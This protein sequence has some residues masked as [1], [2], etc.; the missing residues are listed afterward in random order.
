MSGRRS[1]AVVPFGA[2]SSDSR[3]G[4]WGRQ[5]ARRLVDRFADHP[6]LDLKPVFLVAMPEAS[7][8]AGYLVFGSTPDPALAA[9]YGASLGASHA[10]VGVLADRD[11]ERS[12]EA[13][14]VDVATK[15]AVASLR[16]PIPP[17]GLPHAEA[18]LGEWLAASLGA[19]AP[20]APPLPPEPAYAPLLEGMDEEVN[21]TLLAANDPAGSRAARVRA[22][23][24]YLDA[25]RADAGAVAAE[26]RLLVLAAESIERGEERAFVDLL[27]R[28]IEIAP[29]SW[30]GHYLLGELRRL[31]GDAS[32]AV[33]AF[34]HADS[35]QPLRDVDSVRLAELHLATGA[36][37]TA[38]ARLRRI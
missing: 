34:E 32:G 3:A 17:G 29:R 24:R 21:A 7:S 8:D 19:A 28:L 10:L 1:I 33:V 5:L 31:A 2:R 15:G 22:A 4:A 36:D 35:L 23:E 37:A 14:L 30:R 25:L 16:Q 26:E 13:T 11:G 27:E 9:Q 6:S 18:A 38:R 20:P 12:L